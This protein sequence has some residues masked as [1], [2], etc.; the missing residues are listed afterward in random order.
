[1]LYS[2]HSDNFVPGFEFWEKNVINENKNLLLHPNARS[3]F[4]YDETRS[5]KHDL[6]D[7]SAELDMSIN[8]GIV[9]IGAHGSAA[10]LKHSK[11]GSIYKRSLTFVLDFAFFCG[12]STRVSMISKS[13][14]DSC[15]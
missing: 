1:M 11:V 13:S 9:S 8:A 4:G 14:T 3:S 7:V 12:A 10:Y 6:L 2:A 15:H 5:E